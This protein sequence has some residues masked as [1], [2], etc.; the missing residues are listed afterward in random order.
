MGV[1]QKHLSENGRSSLSSLFFQPLFAE[2]ADEQ[3]AVICL[4]RLRSDDK[5]DF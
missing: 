3:H 2:V 4:Q 1:V 5:S